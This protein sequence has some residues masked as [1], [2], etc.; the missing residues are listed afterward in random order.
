M[1]ISINCK[2][3]TGEPVDI[4]SKQCA[5]ES[6]T[7]RKAEIKKINGFEKCGHVCC[8]YNV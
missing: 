7:V 5:S 1:D 6:W 4:P 3:Q 2:E 8:G